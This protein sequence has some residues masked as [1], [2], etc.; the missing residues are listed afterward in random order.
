MIKLNVYET[1]LVAYPFDETKPFI[2]VTDEQYSKIMEGTLIY[3][4]GVLIDVTQELVKQNQIEQLKKLLADT[5]YQ[6]IKYAEGLITEEEY[7]SMKVQR[8]AWR[9]EINELEKEVI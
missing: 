6:A 9:D 8:Q 7:T 4:N 5:D 1:G 2:E 3:R